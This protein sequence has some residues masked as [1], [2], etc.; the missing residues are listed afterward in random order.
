MRAVVGTDYA[1][2]AQA[3]D[4]EKRFDLTLISKSARPICLSVED[5]PNALGESAGG[6]GRAVLRTTNQS[7]PAK[8]TNFGYCVGRTCELSVK[9]KKSL[10][11]HINYSEFGDPALIKEDA[12]KRLEYQIHPYFCSKSG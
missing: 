3:N 7:L 10:T 12:G 1:F 5:W 6:G 4:A 9:P 2:V 8:D 11:G